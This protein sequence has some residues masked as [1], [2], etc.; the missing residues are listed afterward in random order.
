MKEQNASSSTDPSACGVNDGTITISGLLSNEP[1]TITYVFGGSPVT[2]NI[3]TNGSGEA[4]FGGLAPGSYSD[5]QITNSSGCISGVFAGPV[6][7]NG[8]SAP[9]TDI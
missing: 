8:P 3:T 4:T 1:Y 2:E 7:L 9:D 6:V 5:F